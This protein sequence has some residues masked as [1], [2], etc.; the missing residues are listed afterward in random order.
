MEHERFSK[1]L[2]ELYEW[3]LH[4]VKLLENR[5][6]NYKG[7][8]SENEPPEGGAYPVVLA[9]RP[10]EKRCEGNRNCDYNKTYS[11][12]PEGWRE[13]CHECRKHSYITAKEAENLVVEDKS[14]K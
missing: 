5:G 2:D 10:R 9:S 8:P 7:Q 13:W 6:R 1:H 12:A 11:R 3:E 4:T 14:T